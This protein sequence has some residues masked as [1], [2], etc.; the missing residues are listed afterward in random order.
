MWY[1]VALD[2]AFTKIFEKKKIQTKI[3]NI[4]HQCNADLQVQYSVAFSP[5]ANYT[6]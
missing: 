1:V 6:D 2:I 4:S 3:E 5:Q